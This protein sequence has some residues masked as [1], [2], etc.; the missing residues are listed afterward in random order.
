MRIT[1][2]P[3]EFSGRGSIPKAELLGRFLAMVARVDGVLAEVDDA[4]L[5]EPRRIQGFDETVLS[6]IWHSL[7]HLGGHTQEI[8]HLTRVQL[9]DCYR[10]AWAPS[11]SKQRRSLRPC[12]P[13]P[14]LH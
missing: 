10:F 12:P 3:G 11:T 9:H 2:P 7:E 4:R 14:P 5:L 13:M 1:R 8:I 6:A